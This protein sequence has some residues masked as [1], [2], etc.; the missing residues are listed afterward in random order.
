MNTKSVE[1][2]GATYSVAVSNGTDGLR[3]ALHILGVKNG[4][5]VLIPPLSFVAT[6][7]AVS[8][9]GAI[10][11]FVDIDK[12]YLN[13]CPKAL[14]NRLNEIAFKKNNAV[15]NKVTGRR[16]AA[17]LPVHVFGNPA[18]LLAIKKISRDWNIPI[19]EDAAEALGSWHKISNEK[20]VHCGLL[21]DVG[22]I[23]FNGNKFITTGG[24]GINNQ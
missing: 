17:I 5:E 9:L 21:G 13:L 16:I 23:S 18:D 8:H 20:S 2:T 24:G 1:Y 6:A 14:E 3:L 7:N 10:P 4:D 15:F 12:N 11:H 22:V 19:I